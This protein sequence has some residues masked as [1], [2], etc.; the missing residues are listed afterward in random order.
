LQGD[1]SIAVTCTYCG[2]ENPNRLAKCAECGTSLVTA[3]D[4]PESDFKPNFKVLGA[5]AD[6]FLGHGSVFKLFREIFVS[7]ASRDESINSQ[8]RVTARQLLEAAARL[9]DSERAKAIATYERLIQMFPGTAESREA[10]GN[11]RVLTQKR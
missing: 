6:V 9:E 4:E 8:G 5:L 10:E 7:A 2:R 3:E 1:E 11:I